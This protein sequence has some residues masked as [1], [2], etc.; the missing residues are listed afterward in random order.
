M[1]NSDIS[2]APATPPAS[3]E[4]ARKSFALQ[5]RTV[6]LDPRT[7]AVRP[8]LAD[9]R[10]AEYVFAPHYAAPLPYRT[11]APVTL[12]EGRP[13]GSAVLAA[14]R[15]GE[16]FEVLELA[17]GNAWGIAPNLGLVGYCDAGLL[18]RVQ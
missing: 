6:G 7:H 15:S 12:R 17:G 13:I 1:K 8:D 4:P 2:S 10:L 14:L 16:T 18:E 3:S 11:N 5:G 9:V